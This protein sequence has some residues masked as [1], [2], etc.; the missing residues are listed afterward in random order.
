LATQATVSPTIAGVT[1]MTKS[2]LF[3]IASMWPNG[4][5]GYAR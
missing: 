1:M 2:M 5:D 4:N 3:S